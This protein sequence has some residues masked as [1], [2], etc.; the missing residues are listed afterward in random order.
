MKGELVF[1][2]MTNIEDSFIEEADFGLDDGLMAPTFPQKLGKFF[3]SGL[4]VAVICG[5]LGLSIFGAILWSGQHDPFVPPISTVESEAETEAEATE[6]ETETMAET[7]SEIETETETVTEPETETETEPETEFEL[8]TDENG[9]AVFAPVGNV[10]LTVNSNLSRIVTL[11]GDFTDWEGFVYRKLIVSPNNTVSHEGKGIESVMPMDFRMATYV[12]TDQHW[13]YFGFEIIDE[14]FIYASG[15]TSFDG[16]A[17]SL[18]FDL[19]NKLREVYDDVPHLISNP[20]PIS[21]TFSCTEDGKDL[22]ILKENTDE[23]DGL[24]SYEDSGSIRGVAKKTEQGWSAEFAIM[25]QQIFDDNECKYD[26]YFGPY[27]VAVY[28]I[29]PLQLGCG[30]TYIARDGSD[31]RDI[32]WMATTSRGT[33]TYSPLDC[34]INFWMP[35]YPVRPETRIDCNG[36]AYYLSNYPPDVDPPDPDTYEPPFA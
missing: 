19:G 18:S 23:N 2:K 3:T 16:D 24:L 4:G 30:I 8:V 7:E 14:H 29:N 20:R 21:Y 27:E 26:H 28:D 6:A 11:D 5:V 10:K 25:W 22:I 33:L 32:T 34:G 31:Q 12:A 36:I 15:V 13:L 9:A 1:K 17:I 35:F